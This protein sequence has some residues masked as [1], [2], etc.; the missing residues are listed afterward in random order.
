MGLPY[1]GIIYSLYG[2]TY[3]PYPPDPKGCKPALT[4]QAYNGQSPLWA[5]ASSKHDLLPPKGW[6]SQTLDDTYAYPVR[7]G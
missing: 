5:L 4:G 3:C 7:V 1:L 6:Q 2:N